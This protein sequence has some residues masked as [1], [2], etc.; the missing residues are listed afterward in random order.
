MYAG[1][2]A[3]TSVGDCRAMRCPKRFRVNRNALFK[4]AIALVVIAASVL[5]MAYPSVA[6]AAQSAGNVYMRCDRMKASTAPGSCLVVFTTSSTSFTETTIRIT[7]DTEW[8]SATNFSTTA[9]NY[10]VSTSGL[11]AG[12]TAM[13]GISTATSVSSQTIVFPV[14]AMA[15]STTYGFFITGTGL[16]LNPAASTTIIHTI[17]TTD[18]TPTTNDTKDIAVPTVSDDQIVV[19]ATV[20]PSFTFVLGSNT[21]ALGTLSSA[22]I[23]SGSGNTLTITTNATGWYAWVKDS[24]AGLTSSNVSYTIATSGSID[25]A[26]TTI[27]AGTEGYVLD[28]DLTTNASGGGTPTIDAEYN[29]ATTSAGGTLSNSAYQPIASSTGG[30]SNGDVLTLI[31]RVAISGVTAAASDYTDTITVVGAGVF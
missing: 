24:N 22:A 23:S 27:S 3:F 21:A 1:A 7:L 20:P 26:P 5:Q 15:N 14:T 29:G 9:G 6:H 12:V 17:F 10:T 28:V 11:P 18:N 13:P 2:C 16:I 8:V 19:T 25:G 4:K 30:T 31:P